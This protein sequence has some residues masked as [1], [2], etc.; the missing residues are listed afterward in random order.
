M[1]KARE[2]TLS[3]VADLLAVHN[4]RERGVAFDSKLSDGVGVL[5]QALNNLLSDG[6]SRKKDERSQFA[7]TWMKF[8]SRSNDKLPS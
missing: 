3:Q 7:S 6:N 2:D 5:S 4:L 1:K 8:V